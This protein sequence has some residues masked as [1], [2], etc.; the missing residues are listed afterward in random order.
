M[1]TKIYVL[2]REPYHDNSTVLGVFSSLQKAEEFGTSLQ[3]NGPW[4]RS[5]G[6][7]GEPSFDD[8]DEG[9]EAMAQGLNLDRDYEDLEIHSYFVDAP[10]EREQ[11][12]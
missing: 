3:V 6:V 10:P 11:E 8:A 2:S 4:N 9:F 7:T 5:F 12:T 1:A